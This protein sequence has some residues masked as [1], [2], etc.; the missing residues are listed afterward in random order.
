MAG[1]WIKIRIDLPD[2]PKVFQMSE[3]LSLECRT[4]VGHLCEFWGW[5]DK[6][7]VDGRGLKL[8]DSIIDRK[9][10]VDGF[11]QALRNVEWLTGENGSLELPNFLRHNGLSAKARALEAEA[12]RLRRLDKSVGQVSDKKAPKSQTREEKNRIEK[13]KDKKKNIKKKSVSRATKLKD[14]FL[15]TDHRL[16]LANTYWT[17]RDRP[18]LAARAQEIFDAFT[19]HAKANGKSYVDWDAAWTTW[20]SNAVKFER[21]PNGNSSATFRKPS[22]DD[23]IEQAA[24]DYLR[25]QA[26]VHGGSL[27]GA[28]AVEV[29]SPDAGFS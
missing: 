12:K 6:H 1:D 16:N 18:D 14:D 26:G 17:E 2:D 4:L 10:G 23:Q 22:R 29:G 20:Y 3:E 21:K 5:M 15:L 9:V 11:S 7:T 13:S 27:E 24:A 8:S 19:N 28:D 25:G